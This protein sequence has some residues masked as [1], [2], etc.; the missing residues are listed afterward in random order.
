MTYDQKI[1]QEASAVFQALAKGETIDETHD[2]LVAPKCLQNKVI[3]MIGEEIS[4]AQKGEEGITAARI[5][6]A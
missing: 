6:G 3:D 2:L 1:G 4:C 5:N